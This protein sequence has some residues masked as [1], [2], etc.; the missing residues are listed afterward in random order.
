M[1][2][3]L[4]LTVAVGSSGTLKNILQVYEEQIKAVL[5]ATAGITAQ[6]VMM[7]A[8]ECCNENRRLLAC[9]GL[10]LITAV[11]QAAEFGLTFSKAFGQAYLV[12]YK[13]TATL[14]I[15]YRG[16]L[17]LARRATGGEVVMDSEVVYKQ[18]KFSIEKGTK[19]KIVH[20][21]NIANGRKEED[22]VGAYFVATY[23]DGR[24]VVEWMGIEE[25]KDIRARSKSPDEG[26][27]VTDFAAMCRKTVIRRGIKYLPLSVEKAKILEKALE[28]DFA[29]D[30]ITNEPQVSASDRAKVL[31]EELADVP[32]PTGE[33]KE[34]EIC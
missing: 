20:K 28:H 24:Q 14:I 25:I 8:I 23:P 18:D 7:T 12:P 21:I 27:W 34:A 15:G 22:I 13:T 32:A 3:E 16:L 4:N 11:K 26:P 30:G 33:V 5:P 9:T 1:S 31:A 2:K 29:T 17:D 6:K 10:S 19:T